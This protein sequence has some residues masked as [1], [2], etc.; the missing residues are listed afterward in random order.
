VARRM[1]RSRWS[2]TG[3]RRMRKKRKSRR[4]RLPTLRPPS[5]L[6][7][8]DP[9]SWQAARDRYSLVWTW[10]HSFISREAHHRITYFLIPFRRSTTGPSTWEQQ[11]GSSPWQGTS[12]S[13]HDGG[14]APSP[15][16]DWETCASRNG[17][18]PSCR[19]HGGR[20]HLGGHLP[21][22]RLG[23]RR[24]GSRR[25][26]RGGGSCRGR[27]V[28]RSRR[29]VG[30]LACLRPAWAALHVSYGRVGWEMADALPPRR[31]RRC[32]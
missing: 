6:K 12:P 11:L 27:L 24:G 10:K 2:G 3:Q 20:L 1:D 30:G 26:G 9:T 17:T 25:A 31:S 19:L 7:G 22:G 32:P 4:F 8:P 21:D 23:G 16:E 13:R 15:C 5:F 29:L 14:N 18:R 28:V